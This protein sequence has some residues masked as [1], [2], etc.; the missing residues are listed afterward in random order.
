M[1]SYIQKYHLKPICFTNKELTEL[2]TFKS[3][4][5]FKKASQSIAHENID[6]TVNT[7]VKTATVNSVRFR[8]C[9]VNFSDFSSYITLIIN[10]TLNNTVHKIFRSSLNKTKIDNCLSDI[11]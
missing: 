8:C 3:I 5:V 2:Q 9:Q 11:E 1:K 6:F 7:T 10:K 4:K